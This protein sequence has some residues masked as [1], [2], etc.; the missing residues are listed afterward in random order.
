MDALLCLV[1]RAAATGHAGPGDFF[2]END[3][4]LR[5]RGAAEAAD[6]V[7]AGAQIIDTRLLG[8]MPEGAFS[9][10]VVWDQMLAA[11]RLYG[12]VHAGGWADVGTPAGLARAEA[13]FGR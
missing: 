8:E 9:L 1:P 4:L 12:V 5:R 10:N 3:G 13:A 11:G 7:Y 6:L 2:R